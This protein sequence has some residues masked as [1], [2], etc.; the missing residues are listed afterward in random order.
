MAGKLALCLGLGV[1]IASA[2]FSLINTLP[3]F[4]TNGPSLVGTLDAPTLPL[5][6]NDAVS[7]GFQSKWTDTD[8][9]KYPIPAGS[10]PWGN[11]TVTGSHPRYDMPDTRMPLMGRHQQLSL[12]SK[13]V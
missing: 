13:Q 10:Y 5:F 4:E 11:R 12:T 7:D 3:Q 8:H 2:Q 6:L 1:S 9:Q